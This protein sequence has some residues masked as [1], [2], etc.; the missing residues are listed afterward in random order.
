MPPHL[1]HP[2]AHQDRF[3][4]KHLPTDD[5]WP[6]AAGGALL[7][8]TAPPVLNA[9]AALLDHDVAEKEALWAFSLDVRRWSYGQL[10]ARI[11]QITD[12]LVRECKLV[13]GN[14]VLLYATNSPMAAACWLERRT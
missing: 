12:V 13:P 3:A 9:A 10:R 8:Q 4:Y 5:M 2:T 7:T 11:A 6:L 14:R 1:H